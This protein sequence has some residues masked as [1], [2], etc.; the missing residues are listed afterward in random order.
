MKMMSRGYSVSKRET[1]Y[2][3]ETPILFI[4]IKGIGLT[5]FVNVTH[6][7]ISQTLVRSLRT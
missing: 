3:T 2:P 6:S 1:S 7:K 4:R 5:S